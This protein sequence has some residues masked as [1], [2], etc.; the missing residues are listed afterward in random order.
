MERVFLF[1]YRARAFAA[2]L[3]VALVASCAG[4]PNGDEPS[5]IPDNGGFVNAQKSVVKIDVWT[6]SQKDGGST[7]THS[8]GSGVIISDDGLVLTNAHVVNVYASKIVV[9]LS[10]LERVGADFVGWDHWTDL[11]VIR[12]D[13]AELA[14]RGIKLSSAHF[15]D[16]SKLVAGQVVYAIGTPHGFART[17]TRGIVSNLNRFFEGTILNSGYETGSFNTWIQTDAAINPGNS[18]GPLVLSNGLVVGINT[19]K[20]AGDGASN[21]GFA[22]PAN[23]AKTVL[24]SLVERGRVERSYIGV[25]AAPLQ[26]MERFFEVETNRGVLVRNV[27]PLSPAANA[28]IIPGD[29]IL[30][31][32][33]KPVDGR[34]PEQLPDIMNLIASLDVGTSV[35]L[36]ILRAGRIFE[37]TVQTELLESRVGMEKT[38]EKWGVGVREI[39]KVY[40]RERKIDCPSNQLVIGVRSGYPFALSGLCAGDIIVAV[41]GAPIKSTSDLDKA[42]ARYLSAPKEK[43]LMQ[44]QRNHSALYLILNSPKK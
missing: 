39:T 23:V 5:N 40:A 41:D 30:K 29:I 19:R 6:V 2:A 14:K 22:V 3:F 38:Y 42:Y 43:I 1:A 35:R 27:D 28:G 15:G 12:L 33:S 26:D 8:I 20:Y 31:V 24:K 4:T 11:A 9:T 37:K 13:K 7:T 18:G 21:L 25:S 16:S 17:L 10:D 44:I 34:F 32:D 36:E